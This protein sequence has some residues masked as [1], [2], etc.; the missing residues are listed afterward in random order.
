[1]RPAEIKVEQM[2]KIA[3]V[4]QKRGLE[5]AIPVYNLIQLHLFSCFTNKFLK[6]ILYIMLYLCRL[7]WDS[8]DCD[9]S[10]M[11]CKADNNKYPTCRVLNTS[12]QEE[13][14]SPMFLFSLFSLSSFPFPTLALAPS[15]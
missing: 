11:N 3:N 5:K 9:N 14:T 4:T 2:L 15:Y 10:G 6:Y 1:M 12:I 8:L 13:F 7:P